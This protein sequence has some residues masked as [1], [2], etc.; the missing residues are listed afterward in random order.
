M[1]MI[2]RSL[3][4]S[5]VN[6][7]RRWLS[8]QDGDPPGFMLEDD[9]HS[10][11]LP[12]EYVIDTD[13][14][15]D[16]TFELG[17][18]LAGEVFHEVLEPHKLRVMSGMWAWLSLALLPDLLG[19]TVAKRGKP[20]DAPHYV[21]LDGPVGQRLAYRLIVR[22]AW[23]LVRLHGEKSQV[24]LGSR[25][26]PWGEMAEQLSSRQ[27]VFAHACFW[28]IAHR[29]YLDKTGEPRRGATSQRPAHARKDPR[30]LAGRGGVRRLPLTFRQFDRTYNTR[31][32]SLEQ[33]LPLL[34]R[35]Y[36]KW[37]T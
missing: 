35:E 30:N 23:E 27:Q 33:I 1:R 9:V 5:G 12:D 6:R 2:V 16:T 32:M 18:Y 4:A 13:R 14:R 7:F 17:K 34:P 11:R 25:K 22:T 28:V 26:S 8:T 31:E 24:A 36:E 37:V 20:L 15:F 10:D 29:L 19:R 21:E 3:N